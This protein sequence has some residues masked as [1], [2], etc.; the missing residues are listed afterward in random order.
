MIWKIAMKKIEALASLKVYNLF[1]CLNCFKHEMFLISM[2]FD[3]KN[4][5]FQF[6]Q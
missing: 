5:P 2:N 4:T 3:W 1:A 6:E